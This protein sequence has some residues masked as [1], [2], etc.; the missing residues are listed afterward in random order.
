MG[1]ENVT[2]WAGIGYYG[3]TDIVFI[4][5]RL[6]SVEYVSLTDEQLS[7]YGQRI[8]G[9]HFVFQQDSAAIHA[10]KL[11]TEYFNRHFKL[12]GE[13]SEPEYF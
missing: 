7:T 11:V 6:N 3:T 10:A 8:R 2:I 9:P 5:V 13:V 1:V 12:A 4:H